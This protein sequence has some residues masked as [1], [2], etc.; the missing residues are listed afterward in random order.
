MLPQVW[1]IEVNVN[2][3]MHTNCATLQSLMPPLVTETL[4]NRQHSLNHNWLLFFSVS[5]DIAIEIFDKC[6]RSKPI[7]PLSS[8]SLFSI[9]HT[10]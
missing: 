2:P 6:R 3:A 10:S 9:L 5:T 7:L 1:L 8:S 4:G